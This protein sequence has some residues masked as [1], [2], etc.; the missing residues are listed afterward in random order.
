M[1]VMYE[2]SGKAPE[3]RALKKSYSFIV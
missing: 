1:I 2:G 3:E